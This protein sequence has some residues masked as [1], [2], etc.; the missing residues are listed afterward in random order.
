LKGSSA[1]ALDKI[2]NKKT[3]YYFILFKIQINLLLV[4]LSSAAALDPFNYEKLGEDWPG[5]CGTGQR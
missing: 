5:T 1:A 3:I 2:T 4:I